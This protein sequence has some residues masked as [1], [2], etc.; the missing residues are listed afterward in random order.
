[1]SK[2]S[3]GQAFNF[4]TPHYDYRGIRL[5]YLFLDFWHWNFYLKKKKLALLIFEM[6]LLGSKWSPKINLVESNNKHCDFIQGEFGPS[7]SSPG[8]YLWS[9]WHVYFLIPGMG[10]NNK[11]K[12]KKKQNY[13]NC[14]NYNYNYKT[15]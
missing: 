5:L 11:K 2:W 12:E 13:P 9:A 8:I 10:N 6:E 3:L 1:M 14:N 4:C 15:S 7:C